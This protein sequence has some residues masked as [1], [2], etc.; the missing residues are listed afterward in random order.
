MRRSACSSSL[1]PAAAMA[2]SMC[3]GLRVPTI[4]TST[5][6][7]A[8]VQATARRPTVVPELEL[9]ETREG[10][11][12]AQVAAIY[13]AFEYIALRAPVA[14][15]KL[16]LRGHRPAQQTVCERPI[17]QHADVVV[18]RVRKYRRLDV[19]AE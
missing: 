13:V 16:R 6:G 5:A 1:R 10:I 7:L 15:R 2:S 17:H 11:H 12:D 4:A 18:T 8:S 19:T 14:G 3:L 9:R